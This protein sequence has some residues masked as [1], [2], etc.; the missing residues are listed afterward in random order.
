[1]KSEGADDSSLI[2]GDGGAWLAQLVRHATLDL[3]VVS[4][5][6]TLGG[7]YRLLKRKLILGDGWMDQDLFSTFS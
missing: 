3:G 5:S 1:M 6:P 4:S 2:L 7:G